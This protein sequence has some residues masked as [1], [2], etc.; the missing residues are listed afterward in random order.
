MVLPLKVGEK[1][2]IIRYSL[3]G[4]EE[5]LASQL[6]EI[7]GR[8]LLDVAMPIKEGRLIPLHAGSMIKV[9]FFRE[10]GQFHFKA[11]VKERIKKRIPVLRVEKVSEIHK[12]QRRGYY[13][14][15]TIIPVKITVKAPD[16][17]EKNEG[18]ETFTLDISGGGL[19]F[20]SSDRIE[21]DTEVICV[22][23]LGDK[24]YSL[25][26]RVVRASYV[27]HSDYAYE[28]SVE[29]ID[30]DEHTRGELIKFVLDRQMKMKRKGMI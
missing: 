26:G 3:S 7:S 12:I 30:I 28:V 1:L 9:L 5:H 27:Y 23:N 22:L 15:S 24:N 19:K 11:R 4:E 18:F 2:E 29:F 6:L 16:G 13:R 25:N 21:N 17:I 8:D 20:V 10:N 14:L